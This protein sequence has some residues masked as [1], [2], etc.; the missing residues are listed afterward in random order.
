MAHK[1]KDFDRMIDIARLKCRI[2]DYGIT[3]KLFPYDKTKPIYIAHRSE[4]S[5]HDVRRYLKNKLGIQVSGIQ[6]A[7]PELN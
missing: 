5:F 2:E 1:S 4:K 6:W 7:L 3:V